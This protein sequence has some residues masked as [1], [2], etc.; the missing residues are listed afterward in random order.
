MGKK[1]QA[2]V[3]HLLYKLFIITLAPLPP[4]ISMKT[5]IFNK[6]DPT[7]CTVGGVAVFHHAQLNL[8]FFKNTSFI[9]WLNK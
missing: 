8:F 6:P 3:Q 7:P 1:T 4:I 2:G 5:G 9:F